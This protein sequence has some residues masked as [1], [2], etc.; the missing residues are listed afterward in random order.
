M[1]AMGAL[2]NA[3]R[4]PFRDATTPSAARPSV[5]NTATVTTTVLIALSDAAPSDA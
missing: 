4:L 5:T 2:G 1:G 3:G